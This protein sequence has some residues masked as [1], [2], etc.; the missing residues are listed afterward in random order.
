MQQKIDPRLGLDRS[1]T[2]LPVPRPLDLE[3]RFDALTVPQTRP[4]DPAENLA[5]LGFDSRTTLS[6]VDI[7]G[8]D[9]YVFGTM[10]DWDEQERMEREA[11]AREK[12]LKQKSE[13]MIANLSQDQ[14]QMLSDLENGSLI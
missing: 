10:S 6:R 1:K 3:T 13:R 4:F 9:T 14:K 12:I 11:K 7:G 2:D 8:I 5:T